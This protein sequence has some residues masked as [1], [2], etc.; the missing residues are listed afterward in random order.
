MITIYKPSFYKTNIYIIYKMNVIQK[1]DLAMYIENKLFNNYNIIPHIIN[2]SQGIIVDIRVDT[3]YIHL[4]YNFYQNQYY[5]EY[6]KFFNE[7]NNIDDY[8]IEHVKFNEINEVYYFTDYVIDTIKP[9]QIY[10]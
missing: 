2:T 7:G 1:S 3:I 6:L 8:F 5:I 10:T 4:I 9:P